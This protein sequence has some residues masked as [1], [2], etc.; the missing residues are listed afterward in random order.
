MQ[1][2]LAVS[3]AGA[4]ALTAKRGKRK[5]NIVITSFSCCVQLKCIEIARAFL[6]LPN[7]VFKLVFFSL[8]LFITPQ[9]S[10]VKTVRDFA[11]TKKKEKTFSTKH[12]VFLLSNSLTP[13]NR[14]QIRKIH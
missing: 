13:L 2:S 8:I 5:Q 12:K 9:N 10:R 11:K 7:A 3:F 1:K 4:P 6:K 14:L